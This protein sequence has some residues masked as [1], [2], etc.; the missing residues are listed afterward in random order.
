[1]FKQLLLLHLTITKYIQMVRQT[2]AFARDT[3]LSHY[4][5]RM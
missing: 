5:R 3:L 1:V 4:H 2:I